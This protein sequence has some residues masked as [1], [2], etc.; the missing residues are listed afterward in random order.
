MFAVGL[1]NDINEDEM[2]AIAS[3]PVDE[4]YFKAQLVEDVDKLVGRLVWQ[5]CNQGCV[6]TG[7]TNRN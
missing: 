2:E 6:N 5:I 3:D 4:H 1:T 7:E